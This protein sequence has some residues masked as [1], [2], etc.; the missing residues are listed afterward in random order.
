MPETT[1]MKDRL[2]MLSRRSINR[3]NTTR[4]L[5]DKHFT[6]ALPDGVYDK[7]YYTYAGRD[8][9]VF[10]ITGE[11]F[12]KYQAC[13]K[14]KKQYTGLDMME[15]IQR[16]VK[17]KGYPLE[18]RDR[19]VIVCYQLADPPAGSEALPRLEVTPQYLEAFH[20]FP[21]YKRHPTFNVEDQSTFRM[22]GYGLLNND[23]SS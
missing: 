7:P 3:I 16:P 18:T 8:W 23:H 22:L 14:C 1:C 15:R 17:S 10:D 9:S 12:M 21:E 19:F 4:E 13:W 11:H 6:F 2:A 20:G 5:N